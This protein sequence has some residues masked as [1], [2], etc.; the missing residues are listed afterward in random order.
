MQPKTDSYQ[1][2]L[3]GYLL[4]HIRQVKDLCFLSNA[5]LDPFLHLKLSGKATSI[6]A[7]LLKDD[8]CSPYHAIV[9]FLLPCTTCSTL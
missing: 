8:R 4:S 2:E 5:C 9:C 3:F 6:V 1:G 7:S